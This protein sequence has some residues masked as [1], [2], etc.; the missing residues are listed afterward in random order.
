MAVNLKAFGNALAQAS[1]GQGHPALRG[2]LLRNLKPP[3]ATQAGQAKARPAL[4]SVLTALGFQPDLTSDA[5]LLDRQEARASTDRPATVSRPPREVKLLQSQREKQAQAQE[6]RAQLV[7]MGLLAAQP[8][9]PA[10]AGVPDLTSE[11]RMAMA[12]VPP[13]STPRTAVLNAMESMGIKAPDELLG[14]MTSLGLI[15]EKLGNRIEL[16]QLGI[17]SQKVACQDLGDPMLSMHLRLC[18]AR[19][20]VT[21][22]GM[23]VQHWARTLVQTLVGEFSVSDPAICQRIELAALDAQ[24]LLGD[25]VHLLKLG[26][27]V[28]T[29]KGLDLAARYYRINTPPSLRS[30]IEDY[31]ERMEVIQGVF[32]FLA[33]VQEQFDRIPQV[34]GKALDGS[35]TMLPDRASAEYAEAMALLTNPE[36]YRGLAT[37]TEYGASAFGQRRAIQAAQAAAVALGEDVVTPELAA[38]IIEA[39]ATGTSLGISKTT[40]GERNLTPGLTSMFQEAPALVHAAL[41]SERGMDHLRASGTVSEE[42][43]RHLVWSTLIPTLAW[44]GNEVE[45]TVQHLS[46]LAQAAGHSLDAAS[47]RALVSRVQENALFADRIRELMS[48]IVKPIASVRDRQQ[49]VRDFLASATMSDLTHDP[50][51]MDPIAAAEACLWACSHASTG[52]VDQCLEGALAAGALAKACGPATTEGQAMEV[53]ARVMWNL[54]AITAQIEASALGRRTDFPAAAD[55]YL[56]DVLHETHDAQAKEQNGPTLGQ[57]EQDL[58]AARDRYQNTLRTCEAAYHDAKTW[59]DAMRGTPDQAYHDAEARLD[60]IKTTGEDAIAAA[61][62]ALREAE[63]AYD[64]ARQEAMA[65][66]ILILRARMAN[67]FELGRPHAARTPGEHSLQRFVQ[68]AQ[69]GGLKRVLADVILE[70]ARREAARTARKEFV[71]VDPDEEALLTVPTPKPTGWTIE[72]AVEAILTFNEVIDADYYALGHDAHQTRVIPIRD[73]GDLNGLVA[74]SKLFD[75]MIVCDLHTSVDN[76]FSG[77]ISEVL[78]AAGIPALRVDLG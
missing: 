53:H 1:A 78:V 63:R 8:E 66:A 4:T 17:R 67:P 59:A 20:A 44:N 32:D 45:P 21:S 77:H 51:P 24:D 13:A 15:E 49:V 46:M 60:K 40:Q 25:T 56:D 29:P 2:P 70:E 71:A 73:E 10:R 52:Q 35:R 16:T 42:T 19:E 61:T 12:V 68:L 64:G 7:T 14:Q 74:A 9:M 75:G 48:D 76:Q 18:G 69:I 33:K 11:E 30:A 43:T 54:L 28:Q 5:A 38:E 50:D 27:T 34:E 41:L 55:E 47:T 36:T 37:A 39:V 23:D 57:L 26:E 31:V 72:Q 22:G 3:S 6:A 58:A 62:H 65:R